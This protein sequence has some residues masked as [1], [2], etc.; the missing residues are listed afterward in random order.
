MVRSVSPLRYPGGKTCLYDI[1]KD[2]LKI[3]DIR[4]SVYVEP[5]VGGAGLAL[6][7]LFNGH[8][9]D[10]YINDIDRGIWSFWKSILDYT[11][12]FIELINGT[13]ITVAEWD[14]QKAIYSGDG[15]DVDVVEYGFSTFFLNR[16]NRSGIIGTGGIIG[17][18]QQHGNY[19]IDCRFNKKSLIEKIRRVSK[20]R[21]LIHLSN[22]D[23]LRF[24]SKCKGALPQN[25]FYCIDPP[26]F[27]KGGSLYTNSYLHSDHADVAKKILDIDVAG[28]VGQKFIVTYD[29]VEEIRSLYKKRRMFHF[30]VKYSAQDKRIG[31]ELL[32]ASKYLRMPEIVTNRRLIKQGLKAS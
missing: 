11:E 1:T 20:Y 4:G 18:R 8:V 23:A 16:T 21:N 25:T 5:Y 15:E 12:E 29:N 24:I 13:S 3:N 26:Y 27:A 22:M 9:S 17:G 31:T 30:D 10:I 6:A 28:R 2:I 14:K 7:L 32:V 19:L